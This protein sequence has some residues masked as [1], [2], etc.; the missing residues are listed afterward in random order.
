[1]NTNFTSNGEDRPNP[2]P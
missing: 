2:C 1:D